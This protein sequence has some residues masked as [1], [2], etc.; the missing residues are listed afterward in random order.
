MIW[1]A[2]EG[3]GF[4]LG[5][6]YFGGLWF[7]VRRLQRGGAG[8]LMLSRFARLALAAVTFYALV[9]TGGS[10]AVGAGL[11]GMLAAR[12]YL[13]RTLGEADGR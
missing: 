2:A 6:A 3:T 7:D 5:L 13:L 10:L 8:R 1:T 11:G 4:G 9:I 12:W